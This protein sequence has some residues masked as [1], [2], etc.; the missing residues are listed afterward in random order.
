MKQAALGVLVIV[1][2]VIV[3][4]T[5]GILAILRVRTVDVT[6]DIL[7]ARTGV[8]AT[9]EPTAAAG[10]QATAQATDQTGGQPKAQAAVLTIRP[11]NA[12]VVHAHWDFRIG[13]RFPQTIVYAEVLN[14]AHTAIAT[15]Q[16]TVDCG[17]ETL[18]CSGDQD[19][20]LDYTGSITQATPNNPQSTPVNS[21]GTSTAKHAPHVDWPEGDY[22]LHITRTYVGLKPQDL[23]RPGQ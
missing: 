7:D 10:S 5:E 21:D 3:F 19:L 18:N 14:Q 22:I 1:M 8:L 20:R 2:I 4:S 16:Y 9:Q 6:V 23:I 15:D 13:P 17:S 11:S 12:L